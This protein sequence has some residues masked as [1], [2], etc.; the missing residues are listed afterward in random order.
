MHSYQLFIKV[1]GYVLFAFVYLNAQAANEHLE[2]H[3]VRTISPSSHP[4]LAEIEIVGSYDGAY[5]NHLV[6]VT[7][8]RS[9]DGLIRS[10]GI[11]STSFPEGD[12]VK[13][14]TYVSPPA[15]FRTQETTLLMANFFSGSD[16]EKYEVSKKVDWRYTWLKVDKAL[17]TK[18][19]IK[20]AED[21]NESTTEA[22]C[23]LL[24]EEDFESIDAIFGGWEKGLNVRNAD[25]G[26]TSQGFM[27]ALQWLM[28]KKKWKENLEKIE[29][30]KARNPNSIG[31]AIAESVYWTSYAN[32][33]ISLFSN[34]LKKT[35]EKLRN[36]RLS[37]AKS[38][39]LGIK[40]S[41]S[42]SPLFYQTYIEYLI[43]EGSKN[44]SL[45]LIFNEGVKKHP[46]F[47]PIYLSRLKAF[48]SLQTTDAPR[49]QEVINQAMVNTLETNGKAGL[50]EIISLFREHFQMGGATVVNTFTWP[51]IRN[52]MEDLNKRY[53]T[54][55]NMNRFG[56]LA[57]AAKDGATY[58]SLRQK[59]QNS[60]VPDLW[61]SG[62]SPD[63][64]DSLFMIRS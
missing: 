43:A 27:A 35:A 54:V 21:E 53:P 8:A 46:S 58:L 36:T 39:L 48:P 14:K 63:L 51:T 52:A 30:W 42:N 37:K 59:F 55:A 47:L 15:G 34:E 57:C 31:A 3:S 38:V 20:Y 5:G 23:A 24:K 33:D 50:S 32:L 12:H 16:W 41:A 44:T 62:Y 28:N 19:P 22:F 49:V 1:L 56:E 11:A 29:R 10:Y 2:I 4:P 6:L 25:G 61:R 9:A 40:P 17:S 13:V 45:D 18:I 64:C 26:W 7:T 60:I